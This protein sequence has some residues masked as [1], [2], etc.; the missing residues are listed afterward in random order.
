MKSHFIVP[1]KLV[2]HN[3]K[4]VF[5]KKSVFNQKYH[6]VKLVDFKMEVQA[7]RTFEYLL[8]D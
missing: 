3:S 8:T 6:N 7:R 2:E 5:L 4:F 1:L